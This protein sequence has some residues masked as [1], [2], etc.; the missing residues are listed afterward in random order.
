MANATK[1][2]TITSTTNANLLV[3]TPAIQREV[4]ALREGRNLAKQGK[5]MSEPARLAILD[6]IGKIT[7]NLVGTDAKGKRLIS[8]K[9]VDSSE[10]F[11]W[12]TF[13]KDDPELYEALKKRYTI[14]KGAGEPQIRIDI[15]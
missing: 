11:D 7:S 14:A 10:R 4:K 12:D 2:T 9:L 5:E 8:A 15:I 13:A 1:S 3:L 6:F